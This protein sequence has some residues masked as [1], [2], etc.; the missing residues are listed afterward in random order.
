MNLA[1]IE[2]LHTDGFLPADQRDRIVT[3]YKL[4]DGQSKF[5]IILSIFGGLMVAA[6]I[7]LLIASNWDEIPRGVKLLSGLS[8]M[9][10]AH[11]AA[12]RVQ[13]RH[14]D[15]G[16]TAEGLHLIGSV[17][18]LGNIALIG[19]VYHLSSRPPN[20]ILIWWIGI[21]P[22]VW[23][24]RSK[25]QHILSLVA[26]L[27]WLGMEFLDNTGW[28]HGVGGDG[29][30]LFY[31]TILLAMY[32]AGVWL[33]Q[34]SYRDFANSTQSFGAFGLHCLVLS[35]IWGWHGQA[36]LAPL[37]LSASLPCAALVALLLYLALRTEQRLPA[38]WKW[39]WFGSLIAWLA[40]FGFAGATGTSDYFGGGWEF[41]S[42]FAWIAAI[43]LFAH[44]LVMINVG[45][46]LGS[47]FLINLGTSL[48][49]IDVITAY[50]R[51][52]GTMA[53]TGAMFV[54]SGVGLI[55]LGVLLEKRRRSLLRQMKTTQPQAKP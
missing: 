19:Q 23:I 26:F 41:N 21:A 38:Q 48:L 20:A 32:A 29:L 42:G 27:I 30:L 52:F 11:L 44:C 33:Q 46:M 37:V 40:L 3:H 13:T 15:C 25:T 5:V 4:Q 55:V 7:I 16:K 8:L 43:V 17:L 51:L 10:G 54:V 9:L 47:R 45:L 50:I 12:W 49:G 35:L 53:V 6:G 1:D 34:T 39:I 18:L 14:P 28:F 36:N 31:P 24:L 22:L 2:R